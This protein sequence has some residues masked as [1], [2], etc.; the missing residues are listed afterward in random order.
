MEQINL[1]LIPGRTMP[2]AHASQYDV[3]RTIRFNLFEGDTIYTLDGT[4]TVNVNVRK[5]DG[6]VVTE[7]L[8][9][10]ASASYVEVVT[11]EQMTACSG[12]N[13]AEI[14]IIKGDDT[15]GT[16]NFILEV[17]EDPME[18]GIQSESEIHNLRSQVNAMVSEEVAEQY[19]SADVIFDNVPT[20]GHGIGYTVTSEGIKAIED[21]IN[22]DVQ[23]EETARVT[24][25]TVLNARID[26]IVA[27]PEGSTQGD[28]ELMDIRI[29]V[30]G[31]TYASA[32]DAV[33]GQFAA[34]DF[35]GYVNLDPADVTIQQDKRW[36]ADGSAAQDMTG[37]TAVSFACKAGEK[38]KCI[39]K[40]IG[41]AGGL[42]N[43]NFYDS[44][45]TRVTYINT[46]TQES[47][48]VTYF[49]V[50]NDANITW[51]GYTQ[52]KDNNYLSQAFY[53]L[54]PI[55]PL[56]DDI[57]ALQHNLKD[58]FKQ[59]ATTV[60]T[61]DANTLKNGI[62]S[63]TKG[64]TPSNFP[65]ISYASGAIVW[66]IRASDEAFNNYDRQYIITD[67]YIANRAYIS[68]AW[69]SWKVSRI[70]KNIISYGN[71]PPSL[72]DLDNGLY[73]V[74]SSQKPVNYP[75][76]SLSTG[77]WI[78]VEKKT[79]GINSDN[80]NIRVSS[81]A[82]TYV[83]KSSGGNWLGWEATAGV[84]TCGTD[85]DYTTLREAISAGSKYGC[86]V[87]VY[88]KEYD[89]T[90][91][92]ATEIAQESTTGFTGI[93]LKNGVH[94]EFL[95]GAYVKAIFDGSSSWT[96][97]Y[98]NPFY[99]SGS[100][101]LENL[102]IEAKNCRYCVHDE[103]AGLTEAY[104]HIYK[105]C[106][107]KYENTYDT[108]IYIQCIG[109]GLGVNGTIEIVGGKYESKSDNP[110]GSYPTADDSEVCISY[111]NG[112]GA[113][114]DSF[115]TVRDLYLSDN[116]FLRFGNYG[117]STIKSP[118]LVCGC[119]MGKAIEEIFENPNLYQ[120]VNF[121]VTSWNNTIGNS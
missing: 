86:K 96:Q 35:L 1:N 33:R 114:C 115:I 78:T 94:V 39:G 60:T 63:F 117:A 55:S 110:V 67:E 36:A 83:N 62:V 106:I 79:N 11:T 4:E 7:E 37:Y 40:N 71:T 75:P 52:L 116:G 22:A 9:V 65:N 120:N 91:E 85:K 90:Q 43:I 51:V 8:T 92:F 101:T 119:R 68:G 81:D 76:M 73:F 14:Q 112:V 109:G 31:D 25:D 23:A 10:T 118:V 74:Q 111:H 12:S 70:S 100:F 99:S 89:L 26:N 88:P 17:E 46:I 98:F 66:T 32:G 19:D 113:N 47:G 2:V 82:V 56:E 20:A 48:Y 24:A 97:T 80:D 84:I 107:M 59:Y 102:N 44:N 77:V 21:S 64:S 57:T 45:N 103:H 38:Y 34:L 72:F 121:D 69:E 13:L 27:L 41:V 42:T 30:N 16:L 6:N 3:G 54:K 108:P 18:G 104:H 61:L 49:T 105:N 58:L 29:G 93:E 95:H 15:L 5:T 87:V 53:R 50:P 28:A